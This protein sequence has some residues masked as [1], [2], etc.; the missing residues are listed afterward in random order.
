MI[1]EKRILPSAIQT[2]VQRG[3]GNRQI[4][5]EENFKTVLLTCFKQESSRYN[6][7]CDNYEDCYIK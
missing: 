1:I 7:M 6:E 5:I 4:K 2:G 3:R